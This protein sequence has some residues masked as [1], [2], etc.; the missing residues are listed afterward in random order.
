MRVTARQS[1]CWWR[2]VL[3]A[4]A[5]L[6]ILS[7]VLIASSRYQ[8]PSGMGRDIFTGLAGAA[9][10]YGLLAGP[11]TTV[12]ALSKERREGTLGLLYLTNLR[13]Y[14]VVLGKMATASLDLLLGIAAILPIA[15]IPMLLGGVSLA[16]LATA[17]CA[18]F[19][20]AF[21]SLAAGICAS[22]FCQSGRVA[23]GI[24][25]AFLALLTLALPFA[26]YEGFRIGPHH[27]LA[28]FFLI[29]CPAYTMELSLGSMG[30][31]WKFLL[32]M[33]GTHLAGWILVAVACVNATR[34]WRDQPGSFTVRALQRTAAWL[35]TFSV[36]RGRAHRQCILNRNPILWLESREVLQGRLL[37]II[38]GVAILAWIFE[39][40]DHP[41]SWPNNDALILWP[42]FGHYALCLWIS[43]DAPRRLADDKQSGALELLMCTPVPTHAIIAGNMCALWKRFGPPFLAMTMLYAYGVL[44]YQSTRSQ[45]ENELNWLASVGG[46]VMAVQLYALAKVGVCQGLMS[47]NSLRATFAIVW[48]I[49]VLP[50]LLFF[51][52]LVC[53]EWYRAFIRPPRFPTFGLVMC[54]WGTVHLVPCLWYITRSNHLLKN[55]FRVLAVSSDRPGLWRRLFG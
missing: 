27:R 54:L 49:G 14:D 41:R 2:R 4:S 15:G 29:V 43:I 12:D 20:L 42:L 55:N 40:L 17:A 30:A 5:A 44:F 35:S 6:V 3:V 25:V 34:A 39:H 10:I 33:G 28:P 9:M 19:N 51:A 18:T 48:R 53:L 45:A 16:S 11:L 26:L 46:L 38:A 37:R 24:T 31:P 52:G 22:S 7:F 47:G 8:S 23:F 13:S 50:W 32:N 21:L 36:S 1:R